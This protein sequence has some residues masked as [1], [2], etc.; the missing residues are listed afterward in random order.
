MT[1]APRRPALRSKPA[2]ETVPE[3][4]Q[5]CSV[6]S[7]KGGCRQPVEYRGLC[8]AHRHTHRGLAGPAEPKV[9]PDE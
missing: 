7:P 1:D 9:H 2:E 3:K 5:T 6:P 8:A 4:V